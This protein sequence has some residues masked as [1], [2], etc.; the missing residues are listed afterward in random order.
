MHDKKD[1]NVEPKTG[2][3]MAANLGC[4]DGYEHDANHAVFFSFIDGFVWANWQGA[5]SIVRVGEYETVTAAM[6]EF[7][8]Q[9]ELGER[10][11]AATHEPPSARLAP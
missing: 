5:V 3:A 9:C 2:S 8:A 7:L 10:L 1:A 11:A 6:R 4:S